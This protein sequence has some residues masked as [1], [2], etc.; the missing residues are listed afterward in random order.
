[1]QVTQKL[2]ASVPANRSDT[3]TIGAGADPAVAVAVPW[4][5]VGA[6]NR[7]RPSGAVASLILVA[8]GSAAWAMHVAPAL[9]G[10]VGLAAVAALAY[11]NGA[12][13]VSKAIAPLVSAGAMSY[14]RALIWGA[15]WTVVGVAAAAYLSGALVE[16]FG[17]SLVQGEGGISQPA[18]LSALLGA[19]GWVTLATVT[20]LPVSTTHAISGAIVGVGIVSLGPGQIAWHEL[21]IKVALPLAVSP[22]VAVGVALV[23]YALL[24]WLRQDRVRRLLHVA[25]AAGTG[26]ARGLNDAPK[27]VALGA[28]ITAVGAGQMPSFWL[29]MV[30]ATAMGAGSWVAGRRVSETL[31]ERL[32]MLPRAE[33]LSASVTAAVLVGAAS[34]L[35]LPVST[36]HVSGSA[37]AALG[38]RR[39]RQGLCWSILG[40]ILSAW[41]VTAPAAAA[42][43]MVAYKI[44]G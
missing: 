29:F 13:D 38:A 2:T 30:V 32:T 8:L 37:I 25:A 14:R 28:G 23:A 18:A 1:M 36:T 27:I 41:L 10:G 22:A 4:V 40:Q 34:P 6:T 5:A 43:A 33:A 17:R 42:L 11:S 16:T 31:A 44:A 21:G 3:P 26:F 20:G 12:N 15:V 35:G 9:T 7:L 19:I 39:G 24:R